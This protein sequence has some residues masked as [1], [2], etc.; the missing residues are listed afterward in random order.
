MSQQDAA[1]VLAFS[2]R[3][4][5]ASHKGRA[6]NVVQLINKGAEVAVTKVSH[7]ETVIVLSDLDDSLQ[8]GGGCREQRWIYHCSSTSDRIR[9]EL[10][11]HTGHAGTTSAAHLC[12][13]VG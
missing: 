10:G 7:G 2:E 1:E 5:I 4:L 13:I 11:T 12:V 8:I 6:D 9:D 3:L